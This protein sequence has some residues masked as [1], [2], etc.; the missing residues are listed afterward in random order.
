MSLP[1]L[2]FFRD[3]L[4]L[5]TWLLVGACLQSLLVLS[6][7]RYVALLPAA[8]VLG[9]R[10]LVNLLMTQGFVHN[11]GSDGVYQGR[12]TAMIPLED[13]SF[14]DKASDHEIV[15]FIVSTRS[16]HA[17]GRFAPG[18]IAAGDY[19]QAMLKEAERNDLQWGYLGK[20]SCLIATDDEASNT[21]VWLTYWKTV[22]QLHD[23]ARG[24]PHRAGWDWYSSVAKK[25]PYIGIG[26]EMYSVP[27]G[28][29]ENIY[30]NLRPFGMG[31]TR[32][33]DYSRK[34]V[35]GENEDSHFV[36]PLTAAEGATW[37]SMASRMG[38]VEKS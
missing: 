4:R 21:L 5:T 18:Y 13:G 30:C 9:A 25:Y 6:L 27:K 35:E 19:F 34:L 2:N 1:N 26:H 15:L 29:W 17:Q 36:N 12:A 3:D 11:A 24:G 31:Q 38:R 22:D 37:R 8:L 20:T 32:H 23:F 7:P 10:F 28:H 16:S 14:P 33:I